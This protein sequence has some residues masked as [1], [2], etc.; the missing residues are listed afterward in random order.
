MALYVILIMNAIDLIA[1]SV[2]KNPFRSLWLELAFLIHVKTEYVQ[3]VN[4]L[5]FLQIPI[6]IYFIM[7]HGPTF[8][9]HKQNMHNSQ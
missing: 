5:I 9:S 6:Q 2:N 4:V 1:I 3:N 7:L 8:R